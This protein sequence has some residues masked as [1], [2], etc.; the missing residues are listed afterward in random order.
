MSLNLSQD[1]KKQKS[2]FE[3]FRFLVV[4]GAATVTDLAVTI[5]LSY[6]TDFNE[7]IITS[8]AFIIA[9]WVS[10]FGHR[11]FTFK[12]KGSVLAFFSL[13]VTTLILRNIIVF[14]LV[15]FVIDG[16][17]ALIIAMALVTV[18]TFVIAKFKVFKG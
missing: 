2:L 17:A 11:Y 18:I 9:F 12:K 8:S 15:R 4:G 13:A 1:L 16:L 5:L 10:Y 14:L 7:N 6:F 3:I